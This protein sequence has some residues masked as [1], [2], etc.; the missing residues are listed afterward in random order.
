MVQGIHISFLVHQDEERIHLLFTGVGS[1]HVEISQDD[2]ANAEAGGLEPLDHRVGD[3]EVDANH[4]QRGGAKREGIMS[5][6][7]SKRV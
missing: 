4:L 2:H 1:L 6:G 5:T 3:V 7:K